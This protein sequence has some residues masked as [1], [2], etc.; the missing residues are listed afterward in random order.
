MQQND[1]IIQKIGKAIRMYGTAM[2]IGQLDVKFA[3]LVFALEALLGGVG[4]E[5]CR[6]N[7]LS[8]IINN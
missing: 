1:E 5:T 7:S 8:D 3:L 2:S 4:M 6:E